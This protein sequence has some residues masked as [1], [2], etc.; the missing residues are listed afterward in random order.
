MPITV[1]VFVR[2]SIPAALAIPKSATCTLSAPS[3]SRFA[4][5][6]SRWTT[7]SAC[8]ASSAPAACSSQSRACPVWTRPSADA[9]LERAA[10][11]VLHDDERA[12]FRLTDVEDRDDVRTTGEAGRGERLSGE[13]LADTRVLRMAVGED[14]DGDDA[15][16][17]LVGRAVD[18]A[19]AAAPDLLRVVVAS[20]EAH[21]RSIAV[22]GRVENAACRRKMRIP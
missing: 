3:R 16:Q 6:T 5:F 19:H 20:G 7:P 11:E 2:E 8:A 4:G 17:Q 14:L 12:A 15:A 10:A 1:P 13:P 18:L 9:V 21:G 22:R